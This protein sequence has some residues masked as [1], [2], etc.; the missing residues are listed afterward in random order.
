[1]ALPFTST[2]DN[3]TFEDSVLHQR[4]HSAIPEALSLYKYKNECSNNNNC[5]PNNIY[6]KNKFV[7]STESLYGSGN[8]SF[9]NK[10]P[11][12][13]YNPH[14]Y[15]NSYTI[16][17]NA[18]KKFH[19]LFFSS[20]SNLGNNQTLVAIDHKIEQAMDLVK[21]HLM[22][23]VREE[24]ELLR[25]RIKDL[26]ATALRLER[27]NNFLKEHIPASIL[28]KVEAQLAGTNLSHQ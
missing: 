7:F 9:N 26:E 10:Y 2:I 28:Q 23:A 24:V 3:Y 5:P 12:V 8:Y 14:L 11:Y 27:E 17:R 4:R 16:Q 6:N 19:P 25:S 22:F 13:N 15:G 21:T 18:G 1:M 20:S